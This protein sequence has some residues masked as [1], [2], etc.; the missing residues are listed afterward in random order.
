MINHWMELRVFFDSIK[1][2]QMTYMEVP[3]LGVMGKI[4]QLTSLQLYL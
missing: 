3:V 2:G 1:V 4:E